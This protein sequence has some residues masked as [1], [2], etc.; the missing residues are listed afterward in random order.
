LKKIFFYFIIN[1]LFLKLR[2]WDYIA[3]NRHDIT[4][5]NSY[6]TKQRIKKYYRIDSEILY[7]PVETDRFSKIIKKIPKNLDNNIPKEYY[8]IISALTEFKKIEIAIE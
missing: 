6:N 5:A 7:P 4:L 1:K 2:Q 3:S 8:I